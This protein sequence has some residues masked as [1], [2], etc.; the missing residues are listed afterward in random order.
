MDKVYI[1]VIAYSGLHPKT[2]HMLMNMQQACSQLNLTGHWANIH[3]DALIS[4]SRS[5][6]LSEFFD[7]TDDHVILMIDHDIEADP[8]ELLALCNHAYHNDTILAAPYALRAPYLAWAGRTWQGKIPA[9]GIDAFQSVQFAGTGAMAIPRVAC[10][11]IRDHC[12]RHDDHTISLTLCNDSHR[13]AEEGCPTF[14]DWFRP[15][16]AKVSEN[17]VEYLSEDWAFCWR[18]H[19]ANVEVGIWH[20]PKIKHWGDYAYT[21]PDHE[22]VN[23]ATRKSGQDQG[24]G[25]ASGGQEAND[26][27]AKTVQAPKDA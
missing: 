13:R 22:S 8:V 4:R 19:S 2:H 24:P 9:V 18:A 17:R 3:N 12:L 7:H 6:V 25:Q 23:E 11:R 1:A 26:Q 20:L 5:R 14:L 21:L 10:E 16:C 15:V 27:G